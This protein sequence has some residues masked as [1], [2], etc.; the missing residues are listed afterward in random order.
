MSKESVQSD[1]TDGTSVAPEGAE[2]TAAEPEAEPAPKK[3][4]PESGTLTPAI[5]TARPTA[6]PRIMEAGLLVGG[7]A[8]VGI[9]LFVGTG[10]TETKQASK[11][12]A[13]SSDQSGKNTTTATQRPSRQ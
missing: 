4:R 10:P 13:K 2:P 7:L 9:A 6:R 11:N 1:I 8:A 3:A 12:Q 5:T